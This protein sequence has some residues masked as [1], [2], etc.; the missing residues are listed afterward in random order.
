MAGVNENCRVVKF[1]VV[2]ENPFRSRSEEDLGLMSWA[3][4][5][6]R[7]AAEGGCRVTYDYFEVSDPSGRVF[8]YR[9][10]DA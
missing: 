1:E 9:A 8:R 5:E 2:S 4:L 7:V 6:E 3:D 10:V